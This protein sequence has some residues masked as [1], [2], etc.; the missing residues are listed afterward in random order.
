M[1]AVKSLG[2]HTP[3]ALPYLI[4]EGLLPPDPKPELY[5]WETYAVQG[6]EGSVQEELLATR[7]CVVWSQSQLVRTVYRFELEGE[8]VRQAVLTTFPDEH[9]KRLPTTRD[10]SKVVEGFG[11]ASRRSTLP[12]RPKLLQSE[13]DQEPKP[14]ASETGSRALVVFLKTKA[15]V[16]FLHGSHHIIDLPFEVERAFPAPRGLLLQRR[17]QAEVE[18]IITSPKV[19]AA[20]QNSFF[21]SQAHP[22]SSYLQS[23]TLA[24]SFAASQ[25]VRPSPLAGLGGGNDWLSGLYNTVCGAPDRWEEREAASLYSLTSPLSDIGMV[26]ESIQHAKPRI[27]MKAPQGVS[28]DFDA[29]DHAETIVYVSSSNELPPQT[30]GRQAQ[31]LLLV[32]V[33]QEMRLATVWHGW[34]IDEQSLA[35]LMKKRAELRAAKAR[36]RSSF[37]GASIGSGTATPAVR[38]RDGGRESFAPGASLHVPEPQPTRP[39]RSRSRKPTR[40]DDEAAM[41]L[42][43]DPDSQAPVTREKTRESRRI[44][45]MVSRAE[46]AAEARAGPGTSFGGTGGR[47]HTSFGPQGERRS[48]GLRR[49]RGSTP[50]SVFRAS[51]GMDGDTEMDLDSETYESSES[52]ES[53]LRHIRNTYDTAGTDNVFGC[54]DDRF[55]HELV[56]RKVHSFNIGQQPWSRSPPK[57][58]IDVKVATLCEKLPSIYTED[59]RLGVYLHDDS[60]GEMSA[61]LLDVKKK[62]LWPE[63]ADSPYATI[64]TVIKT[65]TTANCMDLIKLAGDTASAVLIGDAGLLLS[66]SASVY[67]PLPATAPY[68][69]YNALDV[70]TTSQSPD[71]GV[72]RNRIL[73]APA[74]AL[75]FM[76][77]GPDGTFDERGAD[78]VHH[79]RQVKL[80][81]SDSS[82]SRV[83][84]VCQ[85]V[86]PA[87]LG[88]Q[89][90]AT[91][92]RAYN[93]L[94]QQDGALAGTGCRIESVAL[95]ATIMALVIDLLDE[96]AKASLQIGKLAGGSSA[97]I[98]AARLELHQQCQALFADPAWSWMTRP[99]S[100]GPAATSSHRSMQKDR[101]LPIACG[102]AQE[103]RQGNNTGM[104]TL[105]EH[106]RDI[107]IK[108]MLALHVSREEQKLDLLTSP[109][110]DNLAPVIAQL[111]SL[112]GLHAWSHQAGCYYALEGAND[113]AWAF[114]T[115]TSRQ[116][117]RMPVMEEPVG[118]FEW[119]EH[120]LKHSSAEAYPS[121]ATIAQLG[122]DTTASRNFVE[123]ADR[124]TP[125]ITALSRILTETHG[126]S[127]DAVTTVEVAAKWRL[128]TEML[129]T[130]PEAVAAPFRE[131]IARCE[132]EP[133]TTWP[134][135]LLR[136]I[137][138]E[139]LQMGDDDLAADQHHGAQYAAT[140]TP[141][142]DVQ[143]I[144]HAYESPV[145]AVKTREA[146]RHGI[147]QLLF[148]ED[149]RL[150]EAT[151]L[152]HF[153]SVQIA[154]C[155]KQPDWTDAFHF[156][157]QR[158]VMQWVTTRMIAL[159]AGDGMI[160]YDSQTPLM[161][162]KYH[163]PGFS[164]SCVMQ[165]MGHTVTT[166]RSG[167]TEEK[168][169]WAYFHA[170]VS[171]GLRVSRSA[172][173]IDTSWLV[174]NKP[175]DLTNR[176][177]GLLLALGLNGHL[178]T[179]AKW[180]SFKYLTPKHTM[181]SVGL[182][183]GISAS[184]M[185][186]M[187]SLITRMLSVHITSMLPPGAAEL[188]VAP[189]TQTAGLMGIGLLY[190]NTQHRRMSEI[191][192]HEIELLDVEDI[193]NT[194]PESTLREESYRLAAGFALGFMNL[195]KGKDLRGLYG[196]HLPERLLNIAVGPRPVN[197]VHVFDKATA[198]AIM[199]LALVYMKSGDES[200]ARKVDIPETQ[201]QYEHVRPDMLMLRSM[202]RH[203]ILWDSIQAHGKID[204]VPGWL[205]AQLP[206]C[207]QG[208][209]K[210]P[211]TGRATLSSADVPF[212]YIATGLA[213]A[214]SLKYAGSADLKARDEILATLDHF[215][216]I[217]SKGD[218]FYYDAK[219]A[220]SALRRC[221]DVLALA[222]AVVMAGTGDLQTFRYLRRLHGRT[223]AETPYGSHLA[224]HL[225]IGTLFLGGGTYTFS[226]SD[227][228]VAAL[229]VAFYPLW[230]TDVQDNRVHLQAFRHLWVFA[231]EPRCVVA[232]DIDTRRP[233]TMPLE[234]TLRDGSTT[235]QLQAPCLLPELNSIASL[236]TAD[237]AYWRVTLDFASN[238]SHLAAFRKDPRI[239]IRR[240]PAAE[241]HSSIF[242]AT[243][244]A[245][246]S[247]PQQ[248]PLSSCSNAGGLDWL[249]DL[250]AL[251]QH[252]DKA[253]MELLLPPDIRSATYTDDRG[254]AVDGRLALDTMAKRGTKRDELWNL[255]LLFA[256][257]EKAER[258]GDGR[259]RW[260]GREVVEAL[261]GEIEKRGRDSDG[262]DEAA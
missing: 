153:N 47:R 11:K 62:L 246:N 239:R 261:K 236:A 45:S 91:W 229:I 193:D 161:T 92:C 118:V 122:S 204:G 208:R 190:Y 260:I 186:T 105:P 37:L 228:A 181:T 65:S 2:V 216:A 14:A 40:L 178:R 56:V 200:I 29:L 206:K 253:D 139:D 71:K 24:R 241:A 157:Q 207:Y 107:A 177:A 119:L 155:P 213:W 88:H 233:I 98:S 169:N 259:L 130:L 111:G 176:H 198:G 46:H 82:I 162:E 220:R 77:A 75:A 81:P 53:I 49:S 235:Q 41:A 63:L 52:T 31:L 127:T 205:S 109:R 27:S 103:L 44:S 94:L 90:R 249:F 225:A 171:A 238:P 54:L 237:P 250:S 145:H 89:L 234:V 226:T 156:D 138:R 33:N 199:A 114:V 187:D 1:A 148:S 214:L 113:G 13:L 126:L 223:D 244:A 123:A 188:N 121:I 160:H 159:P 7:T 131:A 197:A 83:L 106:K 189:T 137:G 28:V 104:T 10:P 222:A 51:V 149:R 125:R 144:I 43:L 120:T 84:D 12:P 30:A 231:A 257:A 221:I 202:A 76:H 255:R 8:D 72:G 35:T 108:L 5:R 73:P 42:Q 18:P 211:I 134:K 183:L 22:T 168:V 242:S 80:E 182:L 32:T 70:V 124:Y 101:L 36:R 262:D 78:G 142:K 209:M 218:A 252:L 21:S 60:T 154:E 194:S 64:P 34:Y 185:G 68:R 93:A 227:L 248:S 150:V 59:Q 163:L 85:L 191:M 20:P 195:A 258:E 96:K 95:V 232:E 166:D 129:E 66:P 102:L 224:A 217:K 58:P 74:G 140:T 100:H 39:A 115:S 19:P 17:F 173:G 25:P 158:R 6:E 116:N 117:A 141:A 184:Y 151:T 170:G 210:A 110:S 179:L 240:C 167:L 174:F 136:L 164:S 4:A 61:L 26:T 16:Y 245:L 215:H 97:G 23:P 172:K 50:G 67:C 180:L 251:K 192:L 133:P 86:L 201:A 219:L 247:A 254:T 230:P 55:K 48:F 69:R 99:N 132:R 243:L 87:D 212:Y 165:P 196:M 3:V 79:R 9:S 175:T 147:S 38:H 15:H 203:V 143:S 112:L 135:S 256:W 128:N 146:D 152:M 57:K